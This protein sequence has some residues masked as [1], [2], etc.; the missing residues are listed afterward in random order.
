MLINWSGNISPQF[1]IALVLGPSRVYRKM[2]VRVWLHAPRRFANPCAVDVEKL[3]AIEAFSLS[4][5]QQA[6]LRAAARHAHTMRDRALEV[7][8]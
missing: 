8:P 1:K 5:R 4:P 6:V 7:S 2:R 3:T